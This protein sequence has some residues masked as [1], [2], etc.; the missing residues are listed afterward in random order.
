M[1]PSANAGSLKARTAAAADIKGQKRKLSPNTNARAGHGTN[2]SHKPTDNGNA[3]VMEFM[4]AGW[5]SQ[6][7]SNTQSESAP[8]QPIAR[9]KGRFAPKF[10][11]V[12]SIVVKPDGFVDTVNHSAITIALSERKLDLFDT[13]RLVGRIQDRWVLYAPSTGGEHKIN[14][15]ACRLLLQAN[16]FPLDAVDP[17]RD[18]IF[19]S[20]APYGDV[21]F[22]QLAHNPAMEPASH[23][24]ISYSVEQFQ[25][26]Y[27]A[28]LTE[29]RPFNVWMKCLWPIRT[30][31]DRD[32]HLP[33]VRGIIW[34]LWRL[35]HP[36]LNE[37]KHAQLKMYNGLLTTMLTNMTFCDASIPSN[38]R[39]RVSKTNILQCYITV[40]WK[41]YCM[42]EK[43]RYMPTIQL[44][45][46]SLF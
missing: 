17:D 13:R 42:S 14:L 10:A 24:S 9:K 16:I 5:V 12:S 19:T 2:V 27:D 40:V 35:G 4:K 37:A 39:L 11:S 15:M 33:I 41:Q 36:V 7:P 45:S 32:V 46:Q 22:Y 38:E 20:S 1:R 29:V 6:A 3:T 28:L 43:P 23:I 25:S 34:N 31:T 8:S 44:P 21:F 26:D 30:R 18:N